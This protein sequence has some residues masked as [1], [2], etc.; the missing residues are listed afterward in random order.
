LHFG[1]EALSRYA[2]N[3]SIDEC[4]PESPASEWFYIDV[5]QQKIEIRLL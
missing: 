4:I 3:L 2:R 5:Q 1:P